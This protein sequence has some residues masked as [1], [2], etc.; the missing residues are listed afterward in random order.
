MELEFSG[1]RK[2]S[3]KKNHPAERCAVS[4]GCVSLKERFTDVLRK[5]CML[6]PGSTVIVACSGGADSVALLR[7]FSEIRT[8]YP[9]NPVC[10]HVEH[11]IRGT[12]SKEDAAFVESLCR[13]Y[14]I[15]FRLYEVD[16]PGEAAERH[17]GLEMVA[18]ELRYRMLEE[19]KCA[20]HAAA[21]AVAHHRRDQAETIL[22]H[23][24]R[25]CDTDALSGMQ[26]RDRDIIRPFLGTDPD[27]LKAFLAEQNSAWC[28]DL[29]NADTHYTRNRVRHCILPEMEKAYPG[30]EM[31]LCR[32]GL[33]AARDRDFFREQV[34]GLSLSDCVF[35]FPAGLALP[36]ELLSTLHP[37]VG[38]R[39]V[40][41]LVRLAGLP[42]QDRSKIDAV[43]NLT[44]AAQDSA[45][46][47]EGSGRARLWRGLLILARPQS[48]GDKMILPAPDGQ[49]RTLYGTFTFCEARPDETGDGRTAQAVPSDC[50]SGAVISGAAAGGRFQP[51][52]RQDRD[53]TAMSFLTKVPLPAEIRER[54]PVICDSTGEVLWIPGV[55]PSERARR[56]CAGRVLITWDG[57]RDIE[58]IVQ[59]ARGNR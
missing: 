15:P 28:E 11:G 33:S 48:A 51:F 17:D 45:E 34:N 10:V 30:A 47:L 3:V 36:A 59:F 57:G 56:Q 23:L 27:E 9:V 31:A 6:E 1:H 35:R 49:V 25:G 26:W 16:V 53:G 14:Q 39:A 32:L 54:M 55:R 21:I 19:A 8:S 4:P 13:E 46:N 50:L 43:L 7:L 40:V 20:E 22:M 24:M 44:L 52:G 42:V 2:Q 41:E 37:A 18:R 58:K 29:T 12:A 5:H 38:S